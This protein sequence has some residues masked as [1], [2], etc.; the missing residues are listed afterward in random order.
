M[1]KIS[2][3]E[4]TAYGAREIKFD[5]VIEIHTGTSYETMEKTM[6]II[7]KDGDVIERASILENNIIGYD[8]S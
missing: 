3:L 7:F 8:L 2:L 4:K 1:N 5:N 6:H